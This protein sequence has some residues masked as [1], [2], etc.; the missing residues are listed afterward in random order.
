MAKKEGFIQGYTKTK[1][2][3]TQKERIPDVTI[4]EIKIVDIIAGDHMLA[5][6]DPVLIRPEMHVSIF[7]SVNGILVYPSTNVNNINDDVCY[8]KDKT[9]TKIKVQGG[10]NS[11]DQLYW[12]TS[13][14]GYQLDP[15][16]AV[17][18]IIIAY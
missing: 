8:F 7:V 18:L 3:S 4:Q 12:N 16:D 2:S 15:W 10:Y 11:G 5:S 17:N 13:I 14:A 9:G 1:T 6:P